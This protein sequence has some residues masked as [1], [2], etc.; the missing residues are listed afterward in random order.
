MKI[1]LVH[2]ALV[3]RGG[4]ERVAAAMCA[5]FPEAPLYTSVYLPDRTYP[6]FR[7]VDVRTTGLQ[8][9]LRS[10]RTFKAAFP[11]VLWSMSRLKLTGYDLVLSSSTFA[12][13]FVR[14]GAGTPHV[15]Y[16]YT[17]FRLAWDPA[18]YVTAADG[19]PARWGLRGLGAA[20][21]MLDRHAAHRVDHFVT[22]THVT[23]ERIRRAYGRDALVIP[24]PI[25]CS[26]YQVGTG[27]RD[28]YLLVSRLEPYKRVDIVIEAFNRLGCPLRIVGSGSQERRLRER[29]DANI[30]F[31]SGV[32]DA[33]LQTLYQAARAVIVP[34]EE[35]YGLVPLEAL[36]SGTPVIAYGAG[37]VLET[38]LPAGSPGDAPRATALFFAEQSP[39]AVAAA[40]TAFEGYRFSGEACRRHAERFDTRVFTARLTAYLESALASARAGERRT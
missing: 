39:K 20:G 34:Q 2:D 33:E 22:M 21:R 1:A 30:V 8:G 37:G 36:A 32:S 29:A 35:D 4:A 26:R 24:P 31:Q 17:P 25:D 3:N 18:S 10:E 12:A 15:C 5:S 16:C 23:R 19:W 7:D 40:I 6:A 9:L 27:P 11:L 38:M 28:G 13:K 14:V